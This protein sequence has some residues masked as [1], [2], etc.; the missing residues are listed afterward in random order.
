MLK[1][2][3]FQNWNIIRS[4]IIWTTYAILAECTWS[5][6]IWTLYRIIHGFYYNKIKIYYLLQVLLVNKI[7]EVKGVPDF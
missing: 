6:N 3:C 7:T 5:K 1:I 2:P 4:K